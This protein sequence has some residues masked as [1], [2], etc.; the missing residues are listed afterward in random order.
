[1][2]DEL[3]ITSPSPSAS[4]AVPMRPRIRDQMLAATRPAVARSRPRVTLWTVT[5]V[6]LDMGRDS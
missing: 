5:R 4:G 2:V 1:M 6:E 3:L